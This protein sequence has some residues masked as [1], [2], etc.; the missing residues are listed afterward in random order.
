MFSSSSLG[1]NPMAN[2]L[3]RLLQFDLDC[4][5]RLNNKSMAV[6]RGELSAPIFEWDIGFIDAS[7]LKKWRELVFMATT[8]K[9]NWE[10]FRLF[11]EKYLIWMQQIAHEELETF[12]TSFD[13]RLEQVW[14]MVPGERLKA[15]R[16]QSVAES[17][18]A[19]GEYLG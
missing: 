4:R 3:D 18:R 2:L 14:R 7:S 6:I 5:E 15:F 8:R 16:E 17:V 11:A 9:A 13:A 12:F 19:A 10:D 1:G